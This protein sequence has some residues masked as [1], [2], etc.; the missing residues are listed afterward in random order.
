MEELIKEFAG[1]LS[2]FFQKKIVELE[3]EVV[4]L[5]N[6]ID[7]MEEDAFGMKERSDE[8]E[9]VL[10]IYGIDVDDDHTASTSNTKRLMS[11][12]RELTPDQIE[13][14]CVQA[15]IK[16]NLSSLPGMYRNMDMTINREAVER[17]VSC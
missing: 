8:M 14:M 10:D 15:E 7:S 1:K 16:W 11:I 13:A 4:R 9:D 17:A 2:V 12:S 6:K 3:N 5:Q